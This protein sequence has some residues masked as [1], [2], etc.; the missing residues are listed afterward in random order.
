MR[1]Y[2]PRLHTPVALALA[3]LFCAG[4]AAHALDGGGDDSPAFRLPAGQRPLEY[5]ISLD[6]DPHKDGFSGEETIRVH[7]D[8]AVRAL[9]LH[10]RGLDVKR[11][12]V[13][14]KAATYK[15]VDA[16]GMSRLSL[17]APVGPG[18]VDVVIAWSAKYN[19]S[20]E[21]IYKVVHEGRPYVFTQFEAISARDS[22]PCF[23]EPGLKTPFS[24]SIAHDKGDVVVSNT[25]ELK[26]EKVKG[27]ER[28]T[29]EKT[30]PLPMYLVAFA[31]GPLDVVTGKT[32]PPTAVRKAPLPIRGIAPHG[33]GKQMARS[34]DVAAESL[35]A[36]EKYFGVGYP[37]GKMDIVAVPD[38]AAG[39]M[40]NAGLVTFRDN[41]LY[42]DDKSPI[43]LQ[44]GNVYVIAHE[45]AHQWFGDLVTLAWWDD[46]WLNEAFATWME[47]HVVE[48]IR[49]QFH[50]RTEQRSGL[51]WV[52]G[53]DSL[54]SARQIR[55]PVVSKN[56]IINAFDGITY[57]K[58]ASVIAMFEAWIGPDHFQQGVRDYLKEKADGTAT[59]ADLLAALSKAAG[60]DV[61][62]P[63]ATFLDQPGVPFVE[64]KLV[65]DKKGARVELAQSRFLPVGSTGDRNK[66]WQIPVCV[67]TD[68]QASA[69]TLLT[70]A[71]GSLALKGAC[72]RFLHPNEDG[73]GYYRWSLPGD[74]L[75]AL[76]SRL[77]ALTPGERISFGNAVR[78]G[79]NTGKVSFA[80]ALDASVPLATDEEPDVILTPQSLLVFAWSD[81]VLPAARAKVQKKVAEL[82]RPVL[83]AVG[84][85]PK[86]GEDPR[87]RQRRTLALG[88]L[89]GTAEDPATI[90]ALAK[91]GR[92]VL[93]KGKVDLD[94]VPGDLA[95]LAISCAVRTGGAAAWDDAARR[96]STE[97]DSLTR[98]YLLGA[99][100]STNDPTLGKKARD[101]TLDPRLK[102][103]E[104]INPLHGQASDFRTRDAVWAWLP[105][106]YAA[107]MKRLPEEFGGARVPGLFSGYCSEEKAK[108]LEAFFEP[109]KHKTPGME[110]ALAITLESVRLC[111]AKKA[112]HEE[113]ARK[114]FP[115]R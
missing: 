113:S 51:D 65:C 4:G 37:F 103:N 71:R 14:G 95:G 69:C 39:A 22:L 46:I 99:L 11:A 81:L 77:K 5:R 13:A 101:L 59:A 18:D 76:S 100:G 61:A 29:F 115:A 30:R 17:P 50:A 112:V 109:K 15:Q 86:A 78:A 24:L 84:L 96:L 56:D 23:D 90:E 111:V 8:K 94:K 62:T 91:L 64:A 57:N 82:Y 83:D 45:F 20:L 12:S 7:L 3:G 38:F 79:F 10:G 36:L 104:V 105:S 52:T 108:E 58:G 63:F 48:E 85:V 60:K 43:G 25:P 21:G 80:D 97:T 89:V 114:L 2:R 73:R 32:L 16:D 53:A 33:H 75:R 28:V 1:T 98:G 34:L 87:V 70:A 55:Q 106:H 54:V 88:V 72:P 44:K 68:K 42:V 47:S 74:Q 41:L 40:E 102:I 110:R 93:G 31:V 67:R 92:P 107:L 49:P 35:A 9:W 27:R 6:V 19:A 66:T 26:R